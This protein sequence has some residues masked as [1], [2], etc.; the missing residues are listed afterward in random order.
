MDNFGLCLI[1]TKPVLSYEEVA[2]TAVRCGV[3]YLQLREKDLS[4]SA[5]L[6]AA[7]RIKSVTDGTQV[8]F[9]M[10]DRADLALL[11]G[12]DI[13][14]LGQDDVSPA[15]ARK[16][17]GKDM[18]IGLSTHSLAQARA[19]L[20]LPSECR[21]AYIGFGPIYATT[22]KAI[23]DPTVGTELLSEVLS[24]ADIPV[25][26]IGGIFPSNVDTVVAVGAKNLCL[27]RH[28]MECCTQ[29]ELERRITE[30]Q[31]TL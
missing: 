27:V 22:T 6:D 14:H 18:V 3:R 20:A 4:D 28:F 13:L 25:I 2:Q 30:L 19:A 12:A 26:A 1:I 5:I 15:D 8:Q 24:F 31:K 21:P 9:V 16:I 10:N 7:R 17:V 23:A 29:E 11:C